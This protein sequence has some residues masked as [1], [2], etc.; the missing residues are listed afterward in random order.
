M[1]RV[2]V[3]DHDG[4]ENGSDVGADAF[5]GA[6]FP[7]FGE[8]EE[9]QGAVEGGQLVHFTGI[10]QVF[11]GLHIRSLIVHGQLQEPP[12][13]EEAVGGIAL[14]RTGQQGFPGGG[15]YGNNVAS[16]EPG[17]GGEC[18]IECLKCALRLPGFQLAG[19]PLTA[20]FGDLLLNDI[21]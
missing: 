4:F 7:G 3:T 20:L 9:R 18:D 11:N 15:G 21:G 10:E 14:H 19:Y 13:A 2:R 5:G 8:S 12:Y 1:R 16:Q 17:R 6:E